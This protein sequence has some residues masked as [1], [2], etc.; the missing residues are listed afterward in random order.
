MLRITDNTTINITRGD[1]ASFKI[2][3]K[4]QDGTQYTFIPGD[5]I[6]LSVFEK[7]NVD[8][9]VIQKDV[10]VEQESTNVMLN[11][12]KEDTK[13]DGLIN[14][15]ITY[16]YEICLNPETNPQTIIG[17]DDDGAK[18]FIIYPESDV[19]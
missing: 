3:A 10:L 1:I 19:V 2:N 5:V 15:P 11:L 4:N 18:L 6:R 12:T 8:N 7:K 16:W 13:V 14:K 9:V 17:Y